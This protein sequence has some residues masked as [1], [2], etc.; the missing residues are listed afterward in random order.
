MEKTELSANKI[1]LRNRFVKNLKEA[2]WS[3]S[4]INSDFDNGEWCEYEAEMEHKQG[5]LEL[6]FR[7]HAES[8]SL[9]LTIYERWGDGVDFII[10]YGKKLSSIL[11]K[12]ISFQDKINTKNYKQYLN[13]L[14]KMNI[15]IYLDVENSEPELLHAN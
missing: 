6:T 12:I 1:T 15:S 8:S 9:Y 10:K 3:E 7:F 2:G 11:E 14:I 5:N 4:A 13:D